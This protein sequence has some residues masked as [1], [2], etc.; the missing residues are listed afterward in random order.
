MIQ[1]DKGNLEVAIPTWQGL[2]LLLALF[3]SLGV[4]KFF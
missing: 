3:T 1:I 4:Y 2:K